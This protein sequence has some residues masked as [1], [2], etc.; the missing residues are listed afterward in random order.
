[1]NLKQPF[2]PDAFYIGEARMLEHQFGG[3]WTE[4][5]LEKVRKYLPAYTTV[6]HGKGFT[7]GFIDAFAGTGYRT[8]RASCSGDLAL[9]NE[10]D[11]ESAQAYSDGSAR[12]ALQVEPSFDRYIFIEKD[13]DKCIALRSLKEDFPD[14]AGKID[15][16]SGDSNEVI[17]AMCAESVNW[18]RHRAVMF[19]DP[20]GMQVEWKTIERIAS[21]KAIDL[22]YLFP[23]G[24]MNRLMERRPGS[25]SAFEKCLDRVLGAPDWRDEFYR[26]TSEQSLF[27]DDMNQVNKD[28]SFESLGLYIIKRLKSIFPGVVEEQYILR[29]SK[30]S[31]LYMLC[32]AVGNPKPKAKDTALK[33][34][35]DILMKD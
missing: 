20:Y 28:T 7:T 3:D 4:K 29:N 10:T 23:L 17:S 35:R 34:A 22:W 31:P 24:S 5:K 11:A 16:R 30:N 21:T 1:V 25:H 33:I 2:S 8:T 9:F 15:I 12:I 27:E 26:K 13:P 18:S 32:F 19:L 6:L 14:R